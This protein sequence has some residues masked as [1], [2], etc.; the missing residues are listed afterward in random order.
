[1][2]TNVLTITGRLTKDPE[3]RKTSGGK[4][5]CSFT[6][7]CNNSKNGDHGGA[8]FFD[9]QSWGTDALNIE[10]FAGKGRLMLV[11]GR[12]QTRKYK[13]SDG[14]DRTVWEVKVREWELL[15]RPKETTAIA[16]ALEDDFDPFSE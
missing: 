8:T 9:C 13:A 2:N 12:I 7:A 14:S 4:D 1:M 15:D 5:V 6:I 11:V 16:A 10:Q 3:A